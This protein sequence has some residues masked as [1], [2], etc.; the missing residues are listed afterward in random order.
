MF[1][2]SYGVTWQVFGLSPRAG[3]PRPQRAP[4]RDR[5]QSTAPPPNEV[6][7][8]SQGDGQQCHGAAACSALLHSHGAH[9]SSWG[10]GKEG[11]N[12]ITKERYLTGLQEAAKSLVLAVLIFLHL[13]LLY[14]PSTLSANGL[15]ELS[16]R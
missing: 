3:P 1:L 7:L 12:L 5:R 16:L 15:K 9:I 11:R 2:I 6:M 14:A 8:C 10:G 4:G 13:N